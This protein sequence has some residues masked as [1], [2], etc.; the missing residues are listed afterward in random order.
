MHD[1]DKILTSLLI[2]GNSA[3]FDKLFRKY[4]GKIYNFANS[5]LRNHEDSEGVV[6][7]VFMKIWERRADLR[8]ELSFNAYLHKI[9]RN[10]ILNMI[11]KNVHSRRYLSYIVHSSETG[12]NDP[13]LELTGRQLEDR[14]NELLGQLSERRREIFRLSR[15]EGKT[16]KEIASI[17]ELSEDTVDKNIRFVLDHLRTGIK[18]N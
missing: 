16:Y 11:R 14:I 15:E 17:L 5:I 9:A 10:Y 6:Q 2:A 18:K 1:E 13:H 3:A 7:F 8:V 12:G 4:H